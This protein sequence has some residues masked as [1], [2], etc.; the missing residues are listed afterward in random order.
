MQ[1]PWQ[2]QRNQY[3]NT[4]KSSRWYWLKRRIRAICYQIKEFILSDNSCL[5]YSFSVFP[6]PCIIGEICCSVMRGWGLIL[7]LF[8]NKGSL[9]FIVSLKGSFPQTRILPQLSYDVIFPRAFFNSFVIE[10][11]IMREINVLVSANRPC[12]LIMR[13]RVVGGEGA[14]KYLLFSEYQEEHTFWKRRH[15]RTEVRCVT[16]GWCV[17]SSIAQK[18]HVKGE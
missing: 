8:G 1:L 16:L 6:S 18:V 13:V 4:T 12:H 3:V 14:P 9:S 5:I 7:F 2:P 17:S 15:Y 11:Y 10:C